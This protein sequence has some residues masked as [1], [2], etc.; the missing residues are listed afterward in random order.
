M[1]ILV[2]RPDEY[3]ERV[4]PLVVAHWREAG[5]DFEPQ[6]DAAAYQR[7]SDAGILFALVAQEGDEVVGYCTVIISPHLHNPAVVVAA[8]DAIFVLP[9]AR[10]GTTAGR[11]IKAAEEAARDRGAHR[12]TWNCRAGTPFA[13]MLTAHG[14]S[15]ADMVV[16]RALL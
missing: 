12:F 7:L 10:K 1:R 8:S 4:R 3:L 16:S 5:F 2:V 9:D 6:P 13:A 14:Y 15:P 11:L